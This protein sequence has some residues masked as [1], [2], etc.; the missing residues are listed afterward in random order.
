MYL[1][2]KRL[3]KKIDIRHSSLLLAFFSLLY[4]APVLVLALPLQ[5][6]AITGNATIYNA[7]TSL[8]AC[9]WKSIVSESRSTECEPNA[10]ISFVTDDLCIVLQ[11]LPWLSRWLLYYL[12]LRWLNP[13][14]S[15]TAT[16]PHQIASFVEYW[17][18]SF[19]TQSN[20]S[21][22]INTLKIYALLWLSWSWFF[23]CSIPCL[24]RS[25]S[26]LGIYPLVEFPY[27]RF[28]KIRKDCK[29]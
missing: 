14:K 28:T 13:F 26:V 25:C 18:F 23:A 5:I 9:A 16:S 3:I 8:S 2:S 20:V 27:Q 17:L 22:S 21:I 24:I 12:I 7:S 11:H 10:V 6:P 1:N 19:K 29:E 4:L 15:L